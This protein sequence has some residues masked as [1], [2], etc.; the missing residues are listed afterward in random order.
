MTYAKFA[1]CK[2]ECGWTETEELVLTVQSSIR[3]TSTEAGSNTSAKALS[4][5]TSVV[6]ESSIMNVSLSTG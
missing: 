3:R 4:A 2:L 5:S 6:P 1:G